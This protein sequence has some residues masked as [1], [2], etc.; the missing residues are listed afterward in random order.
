MHP[1][2]TVKLLQASHTSAW[3]KRGLKS[4][5]ILHQLIGLIPHIEWLSND[6]VPVSSA[7]LSSI[8]CFMIFSSL[9]TTSTLY[10]EVLIWLGEAS[11]RF[12]N[13]W[14]VISLWVQR[15]LLLLALVSTWLIC[16]RQI[17]QLFVLLTVRAYLL[18]LFLEINVLPLLVNFRREL[19]KSLMR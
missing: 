6:L 4:T 11:S 5:F 3:I 14:W 19:K 15:S 9:T 13:T 18:Y 16:L 1:C 17:L 8:R 10:A 12:H 2:M 7:L